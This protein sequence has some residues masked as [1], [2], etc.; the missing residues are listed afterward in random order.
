MTGPNNRIKNLWQNQFKHVVVAVADVEVH[1]EVGLHV[2]VG[3][4]VD[5]G[6]DVGVTHHVAV[7]FL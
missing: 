2:G 6:V 4:G 7:R 1:V 3:V 5:V